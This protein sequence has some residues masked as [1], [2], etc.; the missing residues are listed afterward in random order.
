MVT[1][2]NI[3]ETLSPT[4]RTQLASAEETIKSG[5]KAFLTVGE[6]LY[7][8]QQNKL[9]REGYK[10]FEDYMWQRWGIKKSAG[11]ERI[12]SFQFAENLKDSTPAEDVITTLKKSFIKILQRFP[13]DLQVKLYN[14]ALVLARTEDTDI[15][16]RHIKQA[17]QDHQAELDKQAVYAS[18][19]SPIIQQMNTGDLSPSKAR[20]ICETLSSLQP[21]V[22]GD[23][24]RHQVTDT[25]LMRLMDRKS[26]T[27]TYAEAITTGHIDV[28]YDDLQD[29][30][31]LPL[32]QCNIR[33][34]QQAIDEAYTNHLH[35]RIAQNQTEQGI[36]HQSCIIYFGN[37]QRTT[38][39]L[40]NA[41][42][43][44]RWN[45]FRA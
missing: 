24:L 29:Y 33:H 28:W 40:I 6:Q 16:S 13:A 23:M 3:P 8:I 43:P 11:Y 44:R 31:Q 19:Y 14:A 9:Y 25:E 45:S 18:K 17:I 42:A 2:I 26:K 38:R 41:G 22:R 5:L 15:T 34:F 21:R 1:A 35:E 32:K 27:N 37:P 30:H 12:A 20:L 4:E 7:I 10:T 36:T 39:E